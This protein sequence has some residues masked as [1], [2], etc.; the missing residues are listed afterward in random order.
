MLVCRL[1]SGYKLPHLLTPVSSLSPKC[2]DSAVLLL[3][4]PID[5]STLSIPYSSPHPSPLIPPYPSL[6]SVAPQR[7]VPDGGYLPGY[8]EGPVVSRPHYEDC[9]AQSAG[10]HVHTWWELVSPLSNF[11]LFCHVSVMLCFV[12]PSIVL[13]WLYSIVQYCPSLQLP[14]SYFHFE[15]ILAL[16]LARASYSLFLSSILLYPSI[17]ICFVLSLYCIL[18]LFSHPIPLLSTYLFLTDPGPNIPPY[19]AQR[20]PRCRS[21]QHVPQQLWALR[22]HC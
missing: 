18:S 14:Y 20:P 10:P 11:V 2:Y 9:H 13:H 21:G 5:H 3:L 15:C 4:L 1:S 12:M 8:P 17:L 19:R 6:L 7:V 22:L 16:A